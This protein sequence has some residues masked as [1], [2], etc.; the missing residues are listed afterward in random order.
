VARGLGS[1]VVL[2]CCLL[3]TGCTPPNI[4]ITAVFLDDGHPTAIFHPCGDTA[5]DAVSVVETLTDRLPASG[6]AS[7]VSSTQTDGSASATGTE[8]GD[9]WGVADVYWYHPVVQIRL[10]QT[11]PSWALQTTKPEG[12]L[13]SF[14]A[15]RTYYVWAGTTKPS[16]GID[17]G[18]RFTLSELASLSDGQVW[19]VPEPFTQPQV[20]TRKE[21][22]RAAAESC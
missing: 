9:V 14:A 7:A 17:A 4:S 1:V 18:V 15:T 20:M 6:T 19:A 22:A 13:T 21:F 10:L 2:L 16:T 3:S 12:L 8:F 5:I 11:P